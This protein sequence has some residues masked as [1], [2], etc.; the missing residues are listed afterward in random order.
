VK[1]ANVAGRIAIA[2]LCSAAAIGVAQKKLAA[3]PAV[4]NGL[5]MNLLADESVSGNDKLH[6]I[7]G[8]AEWAPGSV[9]KKHF[10]AGDEY[11]TVL[12]GAIEIDNDGEPPRIYKAGQAY[13]NR[14]GVVH[15]ARNASDGPS[16]MAVVLIVDKGSEAQLAAP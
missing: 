14:R 12:E 10:H 15:I 9:T 3:A 5:H 4:T 7:I 11:A 6:A 2:M 8:I 1:R 16:R 13:H